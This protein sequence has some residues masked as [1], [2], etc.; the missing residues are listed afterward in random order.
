MAS[1]LDN[2]AAHIAS[3]VIDDDVTHNVLDALFGDRY[4][5][6]TP[7]TTRVATFANESGVA[8]AGWVHP[9]MPSSGVY[10]GTSLIWFPIQQGFAGE[11]ASLLT[12]VVGTRGLSPDEHI[13]GRP[14][15]V[16]FL[17]ALSRH[18][19]EQDMRMWVKQDPMNL[20]QPMPDIVRRQFPQFARAIERYG[21]YIY[22]AAAVPQDAELARAVVA[23]F[24]DIYAWE[25]GWRELANAKPEIDQFRADLRARMFPAV[26]RTALEA[27]LRTR[28]FVILQGPP[29]TGKTRL[30]RSLL[31]TEWQG[32]GMTV[33][34]HPAVTYE[35]FIG[36]I[37]PAV[38]GEA[39]SFRVAPGWLAQAVEGS[40]AGAYL[41]H[42]D[43]I[44]RGDLGRVLGEAIYL[45]EAREI[46]AGERREVVLPTAG[47]SGPR[48]LTIPPGL[49]V[50][51]TMNSADRSIA[52]LDLAV[53]R[54]FA[55]A[56]MWP[57]LRVIEQQGLPL[58]T[59]AF[60]QLQDLF[61][62]HASDESLL[63]LPGHAYFLAESETDLVNRLHFELVPLLEEYIREGRLGPF[64]HELRGYISW[65]EG[66]LA[67]RA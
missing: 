40:A 4:R 63:L 57:D 45:F 48:I 42:I 36:G 18:L 59:Q 39:L 6:Q 32:H 51:G 60:G 65:L 64:E 2:L 43:E 7:R 62:H 1:A 16:R 53:R 8:F 12:L 13:L 46:A 28:R 11:S 35:T 55:F 19:Q 38:H 30:A 26:D 17:R 24:V 22:A 37:A 61:I 15:H 21:N 14:G 10:G 49:S 3:G 34:F 56:T 67:H 25:R 50:L 54:R 33:Q 52:I 20:G 44:N 47:D 31:A 9:E 23:G 5:G 58:A 27:M 29:G 41:L 66:E